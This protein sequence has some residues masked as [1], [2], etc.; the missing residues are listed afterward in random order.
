MRNA[1]PVTLLV[2]VSKKR[3]I[4]FG[5]AIVISMLAFASGVSGAT[6][7]WSGLRNPAKI[8]A[9][10]G[11][12]KL[13]VKIGTFTTLS[14]A[15]WA[16]VIGHVHG[17]FPGSR[18]WVTLAVGDLPDASATTLSADQH[19]PYL[20]QMDKLGVDVFLELWPKKKDAATVAAEIDTWLGKFKGHKSVKGFGIDL[21]YYNK[22]V[23]DATAQLW[24]EKIKSHGANYRLFLKHWEIAYMPP[25]YR[26]KGDLIFIDMSSEATIEVLNAE[27]AK[28]A[29]HFAPSACAF[30]IGYP[31]DEDGMDGSNAT[32]WWKLKDPVK[33]WGDSLMAGIKHPTQEIGLLWVCVKSG[34]SYNAGWDLTKG[35]K[36]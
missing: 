32:G 22:K 17:R 19:E 35:G 21:E 27:F 11:V 4:A 1:T 2:W 24:D 13:G 9:G 23:D 14:E 5:L 12:T 25:S 16:N 15:E 36:R 28:W 7:K 20:A 29:A 30:Q 3:P 33:E 10:D 31:A 34:K 6:L 26:G 18:A 8:S